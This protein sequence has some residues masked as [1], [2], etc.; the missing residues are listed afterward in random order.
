MNTEL[1]LASELGAA[2]PPPVPLDE[3]KRALA[4]AMVG[5]ALNL[6]QWEA[7]AALGQY[8]ARSGVGNLAVSNAL[9]REQ[10]EEVLGVMMALTKDESV[11]VAQRIKAGDSALRAVQA[12]AALADVDLKL[13]AAVSVGANASKAKS[14]APAP[15]ALVGHVENMQVV[16]QQNPPGSGP[17][18]PLPEAKP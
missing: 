9:K 8:L 2:L 18:K 4:R 11:E 7:R 12:H 16:V 6:E 14:A 10:V 5:R 1:E 3:A 15:D 17:A 13:I